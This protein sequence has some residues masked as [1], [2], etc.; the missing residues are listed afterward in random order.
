M[1]WRLSACRWVGLLAVKNFCPPCSFACA[2]SWRGYFGG[3]SARRSA[4]FQGPTA[5]VYL[6]I[7]S[8]KVRKQSLKQYPFGGP[9]RSFFN[10]L[11]FCRSFGV[12]LDESVGLLI[13]YLAQKW[14]QALPLITLIFCLF[15]PASKPNLHLA[16][17][18]ED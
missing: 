1:F 3:G 13:M 5:L 15:R 8:P 14:V 18:I 2:V 17:S 9:G 10:G 4:R 7:Q 6:E 11:S 16:I 12:W